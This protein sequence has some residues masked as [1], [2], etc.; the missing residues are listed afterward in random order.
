M[1]IPVPQVHVLTYVI[2]FAWNANFYFIHLYLLDL[3]TLKH[4]SVPSP[5]GLLLIP[6]ARCDFFLSGFFFLKFINYNINNIILNN[7]YHMSPCTTI[8]SAF[9]LFLQLFY[10]LLES[11]HFHFSYLT[12]A[13]YTRYLIEIY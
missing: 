4:G 10:N 13:N 11:S 2:P 7:V 5:P 12:L 3:Y 6:T 9:V 1:H 8:L